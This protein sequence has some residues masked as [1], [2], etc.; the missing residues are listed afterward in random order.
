MLIWLPNIKREQFAIA[1]LIIKN[2]YAL[3]FYDQTGR[4]TK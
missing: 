1:M 4:L 2:I 3:P